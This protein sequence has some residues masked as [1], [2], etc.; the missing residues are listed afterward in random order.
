MNKYLHILQR[1]ATLTIYA[2][3]SSIIGT[4]LE[5]DVLS[6]VG[7]NPEVGGFVVVF[8]PALYALE[9]LLLARKKKAAE[10]L[11]TVYS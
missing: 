10:D 3:A 7:Q 11:G 6:A 4:L 1:I 8:T 5:P 2:G 9:K